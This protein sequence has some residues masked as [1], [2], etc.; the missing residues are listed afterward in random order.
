MRHVDLVV[1]PAY[2]Y[3]SCRHAGRTRILIVWFNIDPG[4]MHVQKAFVAVA[5][6]H[7]GFILL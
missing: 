3:W 5:E 1:S 6:M 4:C 7:V 2:L